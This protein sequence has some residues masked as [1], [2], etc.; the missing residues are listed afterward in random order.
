MKFKTAIASAAL[1]LLLMV[2]SAFA[3]DFSYFSS[4]VQLNGSAAVAN[5]PE[6]QVHGNVNLT[7]A[8]IDI[9]GNK[10]QFSPYRD[11]TGNG[12]FYTDIHLG[13]D[14]NNYWWKLDTTDLG[15]KDQFDQL[16]G[17]L[18]GRLQGKLYFDQIL[19]NITFGAITPFAS[20]GSTNLVSGDGLWNGSNPVGEPYL[21]TSTWHPFDY[22]T[23]RDR[24]G[25]SLKVN[26]AD[27][28]YAEVSVMNEHK[29]GLYPMGGYY[30][31]VPAPI[32]WWT[33]DYDTAV[34]YQARPLFLKA[35]FNFSDFTDSLQS[36]Q[37]QVPHQ[38]TGSSSLLASGFLQDTLTMPGDNKDYKVGLEGSLELPYYS[39]FNFNVNTSH[40]TSS[41]NLISPALANIFQGSNVNPANDHYVVS[42]SSSTFDGT[43]NVTDL[44]FALTSNPMNWLY[45]R[46]F[47]KYYD[48]KN[49][50]QD[51][52][53]LNGA[54][55]Y[56][57]PF[58]FNYN[59]N[60][61]GANLAFTLPAHFHLDTEY[62]F[63]K[64]ARP[65]TIWNLPNTNDNV[66]YAELRWTGMDMITPKVSFRDFNRTG[67]GIGVP[68]QNR[69]DVDFT[70]ADSYATEM[71]WFNIARRHTKTY[72]AGVD[73]TPNDALDVELDGL[74]TT[75][76]YPSTII[77]ALSSKTAEADVDA[78][79]KVATI[80]KL[81]GY[82]DLQNIRKDIFFNNSNHGNFAATSPETT[83]NYNTDEY[84]K[85]NEYEFG[86]GAEIYLIPDKLTFNLRYD[87][88]NSDGLNDETILLNGALDTLGG[89]RPP[90]PAGADNN[91]IDMPY[92]QYKQSSV[93][94]K[95]TYNVTK[96]LA[97]TGGVEFDHYTYND[98]AFN[99]YQNVYYN[100][101]YNPVGQVNNGN[102][103][104]STS[105]GPY[106]LGGAYASPGFNAHVEF[107]TVAYS[108]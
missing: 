82:F 59:T 94:G 103:T 80:G 72:K 91:N 27:D 84:V 54:G 19:H 47:Y 38:S 56:L 41:A 43:R 3:A 79:Y 52:V 61:A 74:Y 14:S 11:I 18:Y 97:I 36:I 87:Y 29:S 1:A 105:A 12:G 60:T 69:A 88:M 37:F 76:Y 2:T 4:G 9:T 46:V 70:S 99:N 6:G 83:S 26:L 92:D 21:N 51:V 104:S 108:F 58:V 63:V 102:T 7:P 33:Q 30:I 28:I 57:D 85:D 106:L 93:N 96:N 5:A 34:V 16:S 68:S 73:I 95:L 78:S 81:N 107:V 10:A 40:E 8:L 48:S 101:N 89:A 24:I 64:T 77:G 100:N 23:R 39:H 22:S 13:Y 49:D 98:S 90:F 31:E 15:Y 75:D 50:S 66:Y 35:S 65:D 42:E 17:G 67:A 20:P 44:D 45:G 62:E 86:A 55:Q 71:E 53:V 25:G 32:D